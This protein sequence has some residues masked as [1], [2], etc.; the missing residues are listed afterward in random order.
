MSHT[1]AL[2]QGDNARGL[3]LAMRMIPS[4]TEIRATTKLNIA[5]PTA[6]LGLTRRCIRRSNHAGAPAT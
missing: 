6:A 2:N 1:A 3:S 4:T 5:T